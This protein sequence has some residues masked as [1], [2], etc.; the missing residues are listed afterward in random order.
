MFDIV[1]G[2]EIHRGLGTATMTSV[3]RV[4]ENKIA[5]GFSATTEYGRNKT[6]KDLMPT[7]IYRLE[8]REAVD[9]GY[10][11]PIRAIAITT[12]DTLTASNSGDFKEADL[13]KLITSEWRNKTAI[14]IARD[15]VAEDQ[16]GIITC[17]PGDNLRH[18]RELAT[19]LCK[20]SII[21][22]KTGKIRDIKAQ[23][24]HGEMSIKERREIYKQY[25]TGDID[26]LTAVDLLNEGWDS[27]QAKFLINLRPTTSQVLGTQRLGRILRPGKDG[28]IAAVVEFIDN[29]E[30]PGNKIFTFYHAMGEQE[31]TQDK[32]YGRPSR[33]GR[34]VDDP[35]PLPELPDELKKLIATM[36]HKVLDERIF[37]VRVAPE[38]YISLKAFAKEYGKDYAVCKKLAAEHGI[39]IEQHR[40][41][42][43]AGQSLSQEAQEQLK[44]LLAELPAEAPEDYMSLEA[45]GRDVISEIMPIS[46]VKL[47]KLAAEHGITL[48][49]MSFY[50]KPGLGINAEAQEKLLSLPELQHKRFPEGYV[51]VAAFAKSQQMATP[52]LAK[53]I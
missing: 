30:K 50:G 37:G 22:A 48:E 24:V 33:P 8:L 3:S 7:E 23:I 14:D 29:I 1:V 2:D 16:Q 4:I 53:I 21:D 40:F 6:V 34:P 36:D 9:K 13:A 12:G 31:I 18:A 26:I 27:V 42:H 51:S 28:Q 5:I 11:A 52:T 44:L 47:K 32:V 39:V 17:L 45:F 19:R 41:R 49:T 10:L 38:G 15:F 35:L 46:T 43:Q 20:E 25:E